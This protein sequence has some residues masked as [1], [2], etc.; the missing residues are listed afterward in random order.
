VR[1]I[2][3]SIDRVRGDLPDGDGRQAQGPSSVSPGRGR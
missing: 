3:A 2:D 1:A